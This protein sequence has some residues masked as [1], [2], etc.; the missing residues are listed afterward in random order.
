MW[1][2]SEVAE[3]TFDR[4]SHISMVDQIL[5]VDILNKKYKLYIEAT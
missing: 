3:A 4:S 2:P 1:L 5:R